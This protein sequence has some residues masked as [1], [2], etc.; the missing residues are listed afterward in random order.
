LG[1]NDQVELYDDDHNII[2]LAK[3]TGE[4]AKN[5]V[6][7]MDEGRSIHFSAYTD[8]NGDLVVELQREQT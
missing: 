1:K 3:I 8:K 2:L 5:I 7:E 6:Y 4:E